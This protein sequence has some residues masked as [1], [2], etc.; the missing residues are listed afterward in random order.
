MRERV[1]S[2][3]LIIVI[4]I[5]VFI[6][7]YTPVFGIFFAVLSAMAAFEIL[8]VAKVESKGTKVLS[9]AFA[10]I[11]PIYIEY[12]FVIP[13]EVLVLVYIL[14]Q[15]IV[16][17]KNHEK[18]KFEHVAVSLYAGI[19]IPFCFATFILIRDLYKVYPQEIE[20]KYALFLIIIGMCCSW[21]TDTFAYFVGV[22]FGKHKMTPVISP[23]KSIEGAVGGLVICLILN[24]VILYMFNT[25]IF[26]SGHL[27]YWVF[28]PISLLLSISSMFGDL[29]ASVIKR[30]YGAKDYGNLIPGHG[31]IM[32]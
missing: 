21:L 4:M 8:R 12:G 28:I 10:F 9:T 26:D 11:V 24:L 17:L 29:V 1:I 14:A 27:N 23:K 13:L 32:D 30:N 15:L 2:G 5:S 19:F 6:G 18:T 7:I 16:M 20:K 31:G 3:I 25:Y 22:K